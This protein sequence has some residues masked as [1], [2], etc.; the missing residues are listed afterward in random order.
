MMRK[1][2]L[3]LV[4]L[5]GAVHEVRA[6]GSPPWTGIIDPSRAIDWSGAGC[7]INIT[8]GAHFA[9]PTNRAQCLIPAGSITNQQYIVNNAVVPSGNADITDANTINQAIQFCGVNQP[10]TY[11]LLGPGTFIIVNGLTFG[12]N[13]NTI[14][15]NV[16]NNLTVRGSGPDQ[17]ILRTMSLGQQECGTQANTFCVSGGLQEYPG[18]NLGYAGGCSWTAG[19]A[20][21]TK[22][23]T[24]SGCV[25]KTGAGFPQPGQIIIMDQ[26]NDDVYLTGCTSSGQVATCTAMVSPLPPE[27]AVGKCVGVTLGIGSGNSVSQVNK[28]GFYSTTLLTPQ[29]NP[30]GSTTL[31]GCVAS[32]TATTVG[33]PA[34]FSYTLPGSGSN[35]PPFATCSTTGPSSYNSSACL[36]TVD[37][38][39][40]FVSGAA[41]IVNPG[42]ITNGRI[43]PDS[44]FNG[45]SHPWMPTCQTPA[46]AGTTPG[47]YSYRSQVQIA[48]VAASS[49][50]ASATAGTIT[51]DTPVYATN[52]RSSRAPGVYWF[53]QS[54]TAFRHDVGIESMTIDGTNDGGNTSGGHINIGHCY[55]CWVRN[56]RSI[57]GS[58]NHIWFQSGSWHDTVR[59]SY[60]Y[61]TKRG[62]SLSYGIETFDATG[63]LL[64]ENNMFING[65]TLH[66][67]GGS[68]GTVVSY[69]FIWND[70]SGNIPYLGGANFANH[71]FG[72][73]NLY[74]G[75]DTV[76]VAH[77][78]IH[79][80]T[81]G[82]MTFFRERR[83][84]FQV[85]YKNNNLTTF[86]ASAYNRFSNIIG[87]VQGTFGQQTNPTYYHSLKN[88]NTCGQNFGSP[89]AT[90]YCSDGDSQNGTLIPD[91][92][93][94]SR[95]MLRWGNYD[96]ISQ[97]VRWC[98]TGTEAVGTVG[99]TCT[100]PAVTP[101]NTTG[102]E[103]PGAFTYIAANL[104][105]ANHNLP[106]SLY[107]SGK[108]SFFTT[109][110]GSVPFPPIGPDVIGGNAP[111]GTCW[112]GDPAHP[113]LVN[114]S[115]VVGSCSDPGAGMAYSIP[116]Q[117]A[118]ANMVLDTALDTVENVTNASWSATSTYVGTAT[119]TGHFTAAVA[120]PILIQG[121]SLPAYNGTFQVNA[122]SYP[123]S[124][125]AVGFPVS[126]A[127]GGSVPGGSYAVVA[128][129]VNPNGET[130]QSGS[131]VS[132]PAIPSTCNNTP[133]TGNCI[134]TAP[135]LCGA[136]TPP[137]SSNANCPQQGW[138]ADASTGWNLYMLKLGDPSGKFCRQNATPMVYGT[139]AQIS[140]YIDPS[141]ANG[142][143]I[144]PPLRSTAW[145]TTFTTQLVANPGGTGTGGTITSPTIQVFNA[146]L[147]YG[148]GTPPVIIPTT[149]TGVGKIYGN[150]TIR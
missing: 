107:L 37:T 87:A 18:A 118:H 26:R 149:I 44:Y 138:G 70:N 34:T 74:E 122:P 41:G 69:S 7:C 100:T 28:A 17:T 115:P 93:L 92:G 65:G 104:V 108:P 72:G 50:P 106:A 135:S 103:I 36:A 15:T 132:N 141:G 147:F 128:T 134:L 105:P 121:V 45:S 63:D 23:L 86:K 30:T 81:Y 29:S 55:N 54:A 127:A 77:D 20:Q 124:D 99:G 52:W 95:G 80:T 43:C 94:V 48:R 109:K 47:E 76:G 42:N 13:Y 116:A 129:R 2:F 144:T 102:S 126:N 140:T 148:T 136:V 130:N 150:G 12:A 120:E 31:Q 88:S 75:N 67:G 131:Q 6:Q 111:D 21:G 85:V 123:T 57:A 16:I 39:G 11:L 71:D 27:F 82:P 91:D 66:M 49:Q 4:L 8:T 98:G 117:L 113:M 145:G 137:A 19:Y 97:G 143:C 46:Q 112:P 59:D 78:N 110:W 58:R 33:P 142:P 22:T 133:P 101:G 25:Y 3:I 68:V 24:L 5:F 60:F 96:T 9:I 62:S 51:L 32:I 114:P 79:G 10:N 125:A 1:V 40:I 53:T 139:A 35:V 64:L 146:D 119:Y 89:Q 61:G 83:R 73:W 90:I 56:I 14:Y 38:G 84:G